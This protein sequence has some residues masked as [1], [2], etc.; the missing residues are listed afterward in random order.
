LPSFLA[1]PWGRRAFAIACRF[2]PLT[3]SPPLSRRDNAAGE[4]EQFTGSHNFC[5]ISSR[6]VT[7]DSFQV[8]SP[9]E[10]RQLDYL[11]IVVTA[12]LIQA[13]ASH[14]EDLPES[15]K[16]EC[17]LQADSKRMDPSKEQNVNSARFESYRMIVETHVFITLSAICRFLPF[18]SFVAVSTASIRCTHSFFSTDS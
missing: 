10:L 14:F 7:R 8:P 2:V 9:I 11:H 3:D 4:H 18:L 12:S 17:I 1:V 13:L 16:R 6:N 5:L 15:E